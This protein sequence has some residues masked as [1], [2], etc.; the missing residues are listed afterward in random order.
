MT[1]ATVAA[2]VSLIFARLYSLERRKR[3]A[4]EAHREVDNE[5]VRLQG[6]HIGRLGERVAAAEAQLLEERE[7]CATN[8]HK[9]AGE[10]ARAAHAEAKLAAIYETRSAAGVKAGATRKQNREAAGIAGKVE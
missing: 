10:N 1:A 8:L 9:A 7:H 2:L 3:I 6:E 5:T 4:A